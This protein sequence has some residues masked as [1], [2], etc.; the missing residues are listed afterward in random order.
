MVLLCRNNVTINAHVKTQ[1]RVNTGCDT[2]T[3]T[4]L[5]LAKIADPVTRWPV[6]RRLGSISETNDYVT[7]GR[8]PLIPDRR[9]DILKRGLINEFWTIND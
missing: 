6:T 5:D 9:V 1:N 4:R 2:L 7:L 3:V 8:F